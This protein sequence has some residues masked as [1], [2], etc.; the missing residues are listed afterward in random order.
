MRISQ[1]PSGQSECRHPFVFVESGEER[2][3]YVENS[4]LTGLGFAG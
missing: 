3:G 2:E 4:V 1:T